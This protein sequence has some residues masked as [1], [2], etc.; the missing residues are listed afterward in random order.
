MKAKDLQTVE[1]M[2]NDLYEKGWF[3]EE[4]AVGVGQFMAGNRV[5]STQSVYRW[6]RGNTAPEFYASAVEDL[7]REVTKKDASGRLTVTLPLKG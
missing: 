2:L 5:P 3:D 6:R 7:Y 1:G 4:V